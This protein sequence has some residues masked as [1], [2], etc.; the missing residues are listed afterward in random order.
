[1]PVIAIRQY[2]LSLTLN[3]NINWLNNWK[4][5]HIPSV[6]EKTFENHLQLA[7]Y[8]AEVQKVDPSV[9]GS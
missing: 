6:A 1:M 8:L 2:P 4:R 5:E 3:F 9:I 7:D